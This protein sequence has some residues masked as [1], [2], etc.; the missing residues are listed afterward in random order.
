MAEN[1]LQPQLRGFG[2]D[3]GGSGIKGAL[4]D[5]NTGQLIGERIR[6]ATPQ[7]ATPDAVA[8]VVT[9]IT[10]RF[11]WEGPVGVTLPS[12]I[13]QQ[14]AKT[15]ANIDKS[16]IG[17]DI[18]DLFT[19][20]LPGQEVTAVNDADAAGIA[21][22]HYGAAKGA[23]GLVV[24]LTFGTGIGSAVLYNGI[25]IPNTEFGHFE[26]G[27][28]DAEVYASAAVREREDL[29]WTEWTAR[30]ND[31]IRSMEKFFWPDLIIAG[32]GISRKHAKWMPNLDIRTPIVPAALRN[33]AGIVGA[34]YAAANGICP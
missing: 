27:D 20:H 32:G 15:A 5:L 1:G 14:T 13:Q 22:L 16:W 2:V 33:H 19:R 25:L 24:L 23:Q 6:I 4:V 31:M 8:D 34:S 10:H 12:V 21:E 28:G 9:E 18:K 11:S 3:V 7:P 26:L 30:V 29:T 17:T